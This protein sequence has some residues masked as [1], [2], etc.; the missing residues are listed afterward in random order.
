LTH[1]RGHLPARVYWFRRGLVLG[2]AVLLVVGFAHL[3]GGGGGAPSPQATLAGDP[4]TPKAS[5]PPRTAGP[6]AVPTGT[7]ASTGPSAARSSTPA[8]VAPPLAQ[9]DGPCQPDEV[10]VAPSVPTANAGG[11]VAIQVK[12]SVARPACT[13]AVSAKTLAVKVTSGSDRVWSSQDCKAAVPT[14][15]VVVRSAAPATVP[16]T[17]SG[18]R[19]SEGSCDSSQ[20]WARPGYYHVLAAVIGSEPADVQFKLSVPPRPVVTRTAKPKTTKKSN[21]PAGSTGASTKG[22][23]GGQGGAQGKGTKCGGDNAASSC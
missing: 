11:R 3:L 4:T 22:G 7:S 13:L 18:R 20:G 16:V 2:T 5:Q 14:R 6:Y 12:L 21:P 8:A 17:W 19:S 23:Q 9:P 15:S 1:P 10:S